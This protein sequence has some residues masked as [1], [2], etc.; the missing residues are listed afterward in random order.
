[1][2]NK[3]CNFIEFPT[4]FRDGTSNVGWTGWNSWLCMESLL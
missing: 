1:M 3:I 2:Y 4:V